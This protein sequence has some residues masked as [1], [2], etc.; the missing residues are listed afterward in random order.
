M[1]SLREDTG[2][3][4]NPDFLRPMTALASVLCNICTVSANSDIPSGVMEIV[5]AVLGEVSFLEL[6]PAEWL[7][8]FEGF[9]DAI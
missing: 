9:V 1:S 5:A 4:A 8:R 6:L 7:A 2:I 3:G